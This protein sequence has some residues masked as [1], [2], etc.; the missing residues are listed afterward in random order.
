VTAL[1]GLVFLAAACNGDPTAQTAV[2]LRIEYEPQW[3]LTELLVEARRR[4]V[5][6]EVAE[7][8]V[9]LL[10]PAWDGETVTVGVTG[11]RGDERWATATVEV[12][13]ERDVVV[14]V[15]VKLERLPCGVWCD[16]GAVV[17]ELDG[18]R[19]CVRDDDGC[20][21]WSATSA[22]PEAAPF[23]SQ[24]TCAEGCIDECSGGEARCAGN[25][26]IQDCGQND[27]DSC[28]DWLPVAACS[29]DEACAGSVCASTCSDACIT[30]TVRCLD[31]GVSTCGDADADGCTQWMAPVMC[32]AAES[33]SNGA[34]SATCLDECTE[35]ECVGTTYARCG[36]YDF[37]PCTDLSPGVSCVLADGCLTGECSPT[38][39][40]SATPKACADAPEPECVDDQTL[41]THEAPGACTQGACSYAA[42]DTP[43]PYGCLS[44]QCKAPTCLPVI[45]SIAQTAPGAK[46]AIA[47]DAMGALHVAYYDA[48]GGDLLYARHAATLAAPAAAGAG[49][50]LTPVDAA[51]DVGDDPSIV[52]TGGGTV[53]IL[54]YDRTA[55]DLRL[56]VAPAGGAW[57]TAVVDHAGDV[58][59]G[60]ALVADKN[61][62]LHAC[63]FDATNGVL[64]YATNRTGAWAARAVT[65]APAGADCAIGI[66]KELR[67]RLVYYDAASA[68][69]KYARLDKTKTIVRTIDSVGDV[70]AT[71][72]LVVGSD[73][74]LS[75]TYYDATKGDLKFAALPSNKPNANW[76]LA[77]IDSAGDVGLGAS[78]ALAGPGAPGTPRIAYTDTTSGQLKVAVK[79]GAI[80]SATAVTGA[81]GA[82]APVSLALTPAAVG[83]AVYYNGAMATLD[84]ATLCP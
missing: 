47:I 7:Q 76:T 19:T 71:P 42:T 2:R 63:Y 43:C 52:V 25:D 35:T 55:G 62:A 13:V 3:K 21:Q 57:T 22:C 29:A 58:G 66:D 28:L 38:E 81:T 12:L 9:M 46:G 8:V 70:G 84:H 83:H 60:G 11:L 14:D 20:M 17:C 34:C 67:P 73:G 79:S 78:L 18:T 15:L 68:D 61:G 49:W 4:V 82:S 77:V 30:G 37:D 41:R 75:A 80:W 65:S 48:T 6:T 74:S 32:S 23:C 44:G 5:P 33:C 24:G 72:S 53:S 39:G 10:P 45:D 64:K 69:L 59:R 1:Y 50:T 56:A 40:C 36:Q 51:R 26:G 31:G 54:Y 16:E 27:A